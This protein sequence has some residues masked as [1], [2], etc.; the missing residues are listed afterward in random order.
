MGSHSNTI[1]TN[2]LCNGLPASV[3]SWAGSCRQL[4]EVVGTVPATNSWSVESAAWPSVKLFLSVLLEGGLHAELVHHRFKDERFP[5]VLHALLQV[6][7]TNLF[8]FE[9]FKNE[10]AAFSRARFVLEGARLARLI[11][12]RGFRSLG[13]I[14]EIYKRLIFRCICRRYWSVGAI[15]IYYV[16]FCV[17]IVII[18]QHWPI[19][20]NTSDRWLRKIHLSIYLMIGPNHCIYSIWLA[21]KWFNIITTTLL[22]N[23]YYA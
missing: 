18:I 6:V 23:E 3:P 5:L 16:I 2:S 7:P 9:N 10:R 22:V 13:V 8:F 19:R 14:C 21:N 12:R 4:L 17:C 11:L 20:P 1:L 15:Y